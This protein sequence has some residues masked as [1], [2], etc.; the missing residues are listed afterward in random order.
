MTR[1]NAN[2]ARHKRCAAE[3]VVRFEPMRA[4][5]GFFATSIKCFRAG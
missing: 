3:C 4:N 5:T 2:K 1:M